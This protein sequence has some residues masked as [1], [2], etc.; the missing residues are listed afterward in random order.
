MSVVPKQQYDN[1][2]TQAVEKQSTCI[3]D[4]SQ[5]V[6]NAGYSG[7]Q[8]EEEVLFAPGNTEKK[9]A[10][11]LRQEFYEARRKAPQRPNLADKG[12]FKR[13]LNELRMAVKPEYRP[14]KILEVLLKDAV[15]VPSEGMPTPFRVEKTAAVLDYLKKGVRAF[16][17]FLK[18]CEKQKEAEVPYVEYQHKVLQPAER[19]ATAQAGIEA[20]I[21]NHAAKVVLKA[22]Q[23]TQEDE[24]T[25]LKAEMAELKALVKAGKSDE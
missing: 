10:R 20:K 4:Q 9:S 24:I 21:D 15:G 19:L 3:V 16:E 18:D 5:V 25:R 1:E 7:Y 23:E 11:Q 2:F 8:L 17:K 22:K 12:A 13:E 6:S 14:D